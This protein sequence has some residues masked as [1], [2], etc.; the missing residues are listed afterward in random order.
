MEA[1]RRHI[2]QWK[3][4]RRFLSSISVEFPDWAVTCA[5]YVA[6]HAVDALLAHDGVTGVTNHDS[7]KRVLISTNRYSFIRKKFLP[8]FDLSRTVR[9][10]AEPTK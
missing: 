4:N 5:F 3:H 2:E 7:R 10:L 1:S 6:L 8:M 9:Y